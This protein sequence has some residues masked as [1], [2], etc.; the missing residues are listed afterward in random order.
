MPMTPRTWA[1]RGQPD[2]DPRRRPDPGERSDERPL[3]AQSEE[4]LAVCLGKQ[5][6]AR[7]LG[8]SVRSLDRANAVGLL[9][10]PDLRVGRSPR[11]SPETVTRWLR[12]RPYLPGR[13]GGDL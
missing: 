6:F 4:A 5:G 9:P 10:E 2:S 13:K 3:A 1:M 8:I 11:W 12:T 7:F